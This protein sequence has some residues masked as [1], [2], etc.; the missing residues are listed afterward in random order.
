MTIK[1][2]MKIDGVVVEYQSIK[3]EKKEQYN[4][5]NC[6]TCSEKCTNI[7]YQERITHLRKTIGFICVF[8]NASYI[9]ETKPFR[10][11]LTDFSGKKIKYKKDEKKVK[12]KSKDLNRKMN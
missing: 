10:A 3:R 9:F 2:Y 6:P 4:R 8:C 1:R 12:Q 5:I 7:Y 11:T